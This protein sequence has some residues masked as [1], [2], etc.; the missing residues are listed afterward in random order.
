[1]TETWGRL[2]VHHFHTTRRFSSLVLA[3]EPVVL[4]R[5]SPIVT[6]LPILLNPSVI[7]RMFPFRA[8]AG[9]AT[10][11]AKTP[12]ESISG[13]KPTSSSH[14]AATVSF[15][16]LTACFNTSQFYNQ[17]CDSLPNSYLLPTFNSYIPLPP[18]TPLLLPTS[19]PTSTSFPISTP[20]LRIDPPGL[21]HRTGPR[22]LPLS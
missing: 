3:T 15:R 1:M 5:S 14:H 20:C 17:H 4:F 9:S 7:R 22:S 8:I 13:Q 2:F 19:T 10:K 11:S 18:S 6:P 12:N 16:T 21:P